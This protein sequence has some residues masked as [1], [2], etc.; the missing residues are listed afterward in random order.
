MHRTLRLLG[1]LVAA[2]VALA[3][4]QQVTPTFVKDRVLRLFLGL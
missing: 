1:I 3:L 2:S 4:V